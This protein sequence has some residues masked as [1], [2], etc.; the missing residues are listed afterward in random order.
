MERAGRPPSSHKPAV[1]LTKGQIAIA[2][3]FDGDPPDHVADAISSAPLPQSSRRQE[4]LLNAIPR[5]SSSRDRNLEPA[6]RIV[7]QSESQMT[8]QAPLLLSLI[9]A[10]INLLYGLLSRTLGVVG[11]LFPFLPRLFSR[12]SGRSPSQAQRRNTSGRRP[13]NPRDTAARFIREFEEE[14]GSNELPFFENGYAQA[15]DNAK[16]DLKFLLVVLTSPE[17]DDTASFIRDTL[18]SSSVVDFI[19]NPENNILL[20][21]GTVQDSEAYQVAHA[22]KCTKFPFAALIAHTPSVSS[23]AMSVVARIVGPTPPSAFVSKLRAAVTQN[24]E[25]LTRVRAAR[26][27]QQATRSIRQAQDSAY[28]R[29]L[30]QDR[31][32]VRLR[33]EAE[34]ARRREEQEAKEKAEAETRHAQ[35]VDAWKKWRA[36]SIAPEPGPDVK[37]AVRISLRMPS[38]QRVVRKFAPDAPIEELYAFVECS[39]ILQ[40]EDAGASPA[41]EPHGYRHEYQFRLVT[42]MPR[43]AYEVQAGGTIKDRIGRSGNLIVE[44]VVEEEEEEDG[45]AI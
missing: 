26:A 32:R 42:P 2:R 18:L 6:P 36:H 21:A 12:I 44:P 1:E 31:E 27:E 41:R 14:Y 25:A 10:P 13:L 15:F 20:W 8:R 9:L 17:H 22:L 38:G 35:Q 3:F 16:R 28:E 39:D 29:S 24:L 34:E 7:P 37:D 5:T 33:R 19:K 45:A 40:E 30:A 11:Y 23:T 43:E 4:T